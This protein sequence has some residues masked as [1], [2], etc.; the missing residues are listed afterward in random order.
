MR[1]ALILAGGEGSRIS[2]LSAELPKPMLN[3]E[4]KPVLEYAIERLV[5]EG[6]SDIRLFT[7]YKAEVI[8]DY[9]GDGKAYGC[10]ITYYVES[11]PRGTAGE[12]VQH[13]PDLD[14]EFL[15]VYGDTLF[16]VDVALLEAFHRLHHADVTLVLH[17]N[18]HPQ[19]SDIVEIQEDGRVVALHSYPHPD[20]V[21]LPNMVSAAL[22]IIKKTVLT[23]WDSHAGKLDFAHDVFPSLVASAHRV[24]G[25]TTREYIKDMGT[26]ER[27]AKVEQ[28]VRTGKIEQGSYATKKKAIFLDRDGTL[29]RSAGYITRPEDLVLEEGAGE[30]I[31]LIHSSDYLPVLVTNQPVIARG[32]V[33][34]GGLK[35]IHNK[36]EQDLGGVGTYLSA[37]YYCPHHPDKGYEGERLEYKKECDCRKPEIE[38]IKRAVNDLHIDINGS[39]FIGDTT[40]DI[41][42]AKNAGLRSV[43]V[44]TGSAGLDGKHEARA[45]YE[46]ANLLEAVRCILAERA[47]S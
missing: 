15:V 39:W 7:G 32:D 45:D 46:A 22:Y 12:I 11:E 36:M 27:F 9:F 35:A 14:D 16:N 23:R 6:V 1:Q 13:L 41:M 21:Y 18:D 29:I 34:E 30:A 8:S 44:H 40:V 43:L 26:P 33:S 37:I 10:S 24:F 38:L 4:G 20:T 2:G 47:T 28:D 5:S 31:Q 3:I 19:D 25:Y 17:P 42:T